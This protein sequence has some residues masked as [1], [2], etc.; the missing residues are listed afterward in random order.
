MKGSNKTKRFAEKEYKRWLKLAER[1]LGTKTTFTRLLESTCNGLI[2]RKHFK[3]V[4]PSDRI[5]SL[6]PGE[7]CIANL[8][9]SD[10]P[11]SH[12]VG[13][14]DALVYDSFGRDNKVILK[15]SKLKQQNTERD[16]EQVISEDNCGARTVAFLICFVLHGNDVCKY[17]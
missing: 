2:G 16:A 1:L 17:I 6:G 11:G 15:D 12:W 5:P 3:G 14:T 9:K 4:F 10:Q 7:C 13:I 8:D